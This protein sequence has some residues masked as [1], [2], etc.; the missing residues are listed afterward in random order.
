MDR[1]RRASHGEDDVRSLV[2]MVDYDGR[3]PLHL[4]A[5]E[6]HAGAARILLEN[7]AATHVR[8]RWGQLPLEIARRHR[9]KQVI[10]ALRAAADRDISAASRGSVSSAEGTDD[11]GGMHA[12][13]PASGRNNSSATSVPLL[14]VVSTQQ[15]AAGSPRALKQTFGTVVVT[16]STRLLIEAAARGDVDEVRR[17][18]AKGADVNAEDYDGRTP[19]HLA[20][21]CGQVQ[22]VKYLLR[23]K[24]TQVTVFDRFGTTPLGEAMQTGDDAG[25]AIA[26]L[27][28]AHGAVNIRPV[29]GARLCAFAA[30]GELDELLEQDAAGEDLN[31][32]DYDGSFVLSFFRSFVRSPSP[33]F[34]LLLFCIISCEVCSLSFGLVLVGQGELRFI[35]LCVR[36]TPTLFVGCLNEV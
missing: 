7:G 27:L 2:N 34:V 21:A 32:A 5:T 8:D 29:V 28:R 17:L 18:V 10:A 23:L 14:N 20:A 33:S 35:S 6:G 31:S 36:G 24:T 1:A 13:R 12:R 26:A 30:A 19:L 15:H 4:A 22:V 9:H 25:R 11:E 16:A 3:T